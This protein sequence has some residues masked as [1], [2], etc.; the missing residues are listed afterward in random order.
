MKK[1]TRET[2]NEL[3]DIF[4]KIENILSRENEKNWIRGIR[5][6]QIELNQVKSDNSNIELVF[7]EIEREF[8]RMGSGKA[9]FADYFISR[10]DFE[11]E[12]KVNEKLFFLVDKAWTLL[13]KGGKA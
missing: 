2:I 3:I 12:K 6:I 7:S 1:I 4:E 5:F 9:G 10:D 8:R 11:E 13:I